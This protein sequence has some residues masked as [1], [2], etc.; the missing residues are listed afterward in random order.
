MAAR[1]ARARPSV[2]PPPCI[3]EATRG[4]LGRVIR[5]AEITET[6]A[7]A[8]RL[9]GRDVVICGMETRV[10]RAL[11]RKIENQVG[12]NELDP[13]H[14]TAGPYALPHFHQVTRNPPGHTFYE[15]ARRKAAKK[16]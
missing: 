9:A 6:Q 5:G 7:V 2:P 14:A 11:A 12:P 16:P 15:T 1:K 10:N 3:C 13:P 4:S 8:A